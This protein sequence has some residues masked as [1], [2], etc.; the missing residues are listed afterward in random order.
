[1]KGEKDTKSVGNTK[2]KRF[3][4]DGKH[5]DKTNIKRGKKY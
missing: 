3:V 2:V 4:S 1:M 5:L